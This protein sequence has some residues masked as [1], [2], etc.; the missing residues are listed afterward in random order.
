MLLFSYYSFSDFAWF[1]GFDSFE[2]YWPGILQAVSTGMDL[3]FSSW[4]DQGYECGGENYR[5]E[6]PFS[7]YHS[8]DAY[9]QH[10]CPLFC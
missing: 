3:M 1:D 2:A 7:L 6:E 4:L 8:K 10:N 5:D 9:Y